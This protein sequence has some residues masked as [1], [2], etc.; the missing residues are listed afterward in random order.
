MRRLALGDARVVDLFT[1]GG[2]P[3]LALLVAL[4]QR[5]IT[6][7]DRVTQ[8]RDFFAFGRAVAT[9]TAVRLATLRL[10]TTR[11]HAVIV[12]VTATGEGEK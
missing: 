6:V 7:V 2:I 10:G 8:L 5:A 4:V 12:V 3:D 9:G 1:L 11:T